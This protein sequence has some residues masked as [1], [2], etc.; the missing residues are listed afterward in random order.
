M[1]DCNDLDDKDIKELNDC[2]ELFISK[3]DQENSDIYDVKM[4]EI[5]SKIAEKLDTPKETLWKL[6]TALHDM[7]IIKNIGFAC[8]RTKP[9]KI[10]HAETVGR[11]RRSASI[12]QMNTT[13]ST[14]RSILAYITA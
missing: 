3:R 6:S 8:I 12:V 11:T 10:F 2:Y 7:T 14:A 1:D 5:L 13:S 4:K 9:D